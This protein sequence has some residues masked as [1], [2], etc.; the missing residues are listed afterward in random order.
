V[1]L[2]IRHEKLET[3]EKLK[4]TSLYIRRPISGS[5]SPDIYLSYGG[6]LKGTGKKSSPERIQRDSELFY[7]LQPIAEDKLPKNLLSGHF[8]SGDLTFFKDSAI[9]KV[10]YVV[11]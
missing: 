11:Y 2:H 4:E 8:L 6:L 9:S 5:L 1:R 7:Y 3:L 10:V